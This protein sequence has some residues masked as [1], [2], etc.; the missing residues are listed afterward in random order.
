MQVVHVGDG[1]QHKMTK[2][3]L[4]G[5]LLAC[6]LFAVKVRRWRSTRISDSV[7]NEI[8]REKMRPMFEAIVNQHADLLKPV[9]V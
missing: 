9:W 8:L 7:R 4:F 2:N 3:L 5:D 6:T 1:M